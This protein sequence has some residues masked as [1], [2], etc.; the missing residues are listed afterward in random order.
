MSALSAAWSAMKREYYCPTCMWSLEFGRVPAVA[1]PH[2]LF[3]VARCWNPR[4]KRDV[5]L[6]DEAVFK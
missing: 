4:C 5:I 2:R 6:V 3:W 1:P